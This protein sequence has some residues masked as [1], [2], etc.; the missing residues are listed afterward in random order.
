MNITLG[1]L[2]SEDLRALQDLNLLPD[3]LEANDTHTSTPSRVA[4]PTQNQE[5][6]H[7]A[8]ASSQQ[9]NHPLTSQL[10]RRGR[11]GNLAWFEEMLAGSRLGQMQHTRRGVGVSN[12]GT[13]TVEWEVSEFHDDGTGSPG[14]ASGSKRKIGEV[15]EDDD[16]SMKQ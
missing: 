4:G 13:T 16:I 9:Q 8:T 7:I 6:T 11:T 14:T 15:G 5:S 12:D 10:R 3:D 1:S 2:L